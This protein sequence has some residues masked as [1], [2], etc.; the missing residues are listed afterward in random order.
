MG[1]EIRDRDT[2]LIL[3]GRDQTTPI[4][5]RTAVALRTGL[6]HLLA[7]AS[8][9]LRALQAAW[10]SSH[11]F[12]HLLQWCAW[13]IVVYEGGGGDEQ[14]RTVGTHRGL[15]HGAPRMRTNLRSPLLAARHFCSGPA[16]HASTCR[17]PPVRAPPPLLLPPVAAATLHSSQSALLLLMSLPRRHARGGRSA[18][19]LASLAR[20]FCPL[21][22]LCFCQKTV[23]ANR[24]ITRR[25]TLCKGN[26]R[27]VVLGAFLS[28]PPRHVCARDRRCCSG[29]GCVQLSAGLLGIGCRV[30]R[31]GLFQTRAQTDV[32]TGAHPNPTRPDL[33]I[34]GRR[35]VHRAR[36]LRPGVLPTQ[37]DTCIALQRCAAAAA[38]AAAPPAPPSRRRHQ[39]P[40]KDTVL[41]VLCCCALP[42]RD[43]S[44]RAPGPARQFPKH[45][46]TLPH[47]PHR[48]LHILCPFC[49]VSRTRTPSPTS[50][51]SRRAR[52]A[53]CAASPTPSSTRSA[54][55]TTRST[56]STSGV[57]I[58]SVCALH[59]HVLGRPS[60]AIAGLQPL[61]T[62]LNPS[63]TL[64]PLQARRTRWAMPTPH[65]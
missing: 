20:R 54:R 5:R 48:L 44:A 1:S 28:P 34:C 32:R 55:A 30:P 4:P 39:R 45:H 37:S 6:G 35:R 33:P 56:W 2:V 15:D 7:S 65:S 26:A 59:G 38:V 11:S 10:K 23:W 40:C 58:L 61:P 62:P 16:S 57:C 63:P 19:P 9:A 8:A 14:S 60:T 42:C 24:A 12:W 43:C 25:P 49:P 18:C 31:Q 41:A 29:C 22:L 3:G 36:R 52:R 51:P 17:E 21:C 47:P 50:M 13:V 64:L 46:P 27:L 53:S